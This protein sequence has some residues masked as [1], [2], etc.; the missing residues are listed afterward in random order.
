V[1]AAL[2]LT[3]SATGAHHRESGGGAGGVASRG[4][5]ACDVRDGCQ[6]DAQLP[7]WSKRAP[8]VGPRPY[9]AASCRPRSSP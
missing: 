8:R 6:V 1:R 9:L 2:H 3:R 5:V 4:G 7:V